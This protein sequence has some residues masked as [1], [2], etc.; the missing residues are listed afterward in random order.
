[1]P[2]AGSKVLVRAGH[3][4]TYDVSSDAVIRSVHVAG[5][6]SFA[7]DRDTR[8]DVG[9]LIVRP[10]ED[11]SETGIGTAPGAAGEAHEHH[12]HD[13]GNASGPRPALEIG[14]ADRPIDANHTA[15]IRLTYVDG[16]DKDTCPALVDSG[17]RM[18]LFG[19]A[20][21]RT[22][23]K[24][25]TT[26]KANDA[27]LA[28]AEPVSGWKA[29]DKLIVVTTAFPDFFVKDK[30]AIEGAV[31]DRS[32]TEERTIKSIDGKT[33]TLDAP[34]KH[35]HVVIN[36]GEWA[37][38]V[39]NLSRNVI[40][41]SAD[42]KGVRGH[43]MYHRG[44]TGS[45]AYAEF[46]HLGKE[47][48]LGRYPIHFHQVGD[49]MRGSS[50]IGA[51]VWDS[52][53]RWVTIHGT[54]Y[55]VI[56]DVVG[57]QS[58]GHGF[59]CEDGTEVY[60]TFDRN[61]AVQAMLGK[62]LPQ[63]VLAFDKN[64]GGGFWWANSENS[65]TRNVAAECDQH[66]FRYE[67]IGKSDKFAFDP[68]L[69]IR[70]ADGSKKPVDV[71]TLPFIRFDDNEAHSQRR[72]ALN[73]GGMRALSGKDDYKDPST[74]GSSKPVFDDDKVKGGDVGGVGPDRAHPFVIRNFK[75]WTSHWSFHSGTPSVT[76]DGL[77][78]Y[79][80]NYGIWRC[81]ARLA[82]FKNMSFE[83]TRRKD[84]FMNFG[85]NSSL[86]DDYDKFLGPKDDFAPV[87]V[88]TR[89]QRTSSGDLKVSGT[90]SDNGEVTKVLVNGKPAKPTAANF[91]QWEI[92]L[93]G[94]D[95]QAAKITAGGTDKAGNTE[96]TP[97]ELTLDAKPAVAVVR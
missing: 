47:G 82:E 79:D 20:M 6:L 83:K 62:T 66:G 31:K 53:N 42:P 35:E 15:L 17:G 29:G 63:Q 16:M 51:S 11:L 70:Q 56:R 18:D 87:T 61:L 78:T 37:G 5:T 89:V 95:A 75:A 41:E 57:Y 45:I 24:L 86:P 14:T 3:Q 73:L 69:E 44:S 30:P 2:P 85:G 72:F 38:E 43:T 88:V 65:F 34:L 26:A 54:D 91:A 58:I 68:V 52:G 25:G 46:R 92:T 39:A 8:L 19:A 93:G 50:V 7:P 80:S 74:A 28:L 71:R 21:N 1:V 55:L 10:G 81:N 60:N 12:H 96:K 84:L 27:T 22:W 59:F 77:H 67:V 94:A 49:S 13:A 33:I 36:N 9:L 90:T 40:I 97:H 32:E 23:V 76:V 64:D 4:V 48:A